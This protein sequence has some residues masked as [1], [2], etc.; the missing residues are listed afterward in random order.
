[1]VNA[2]IICGKSVFGM[3]L[4]LDAFVRLHANDEDGVTYREKASTTATSLKSVSCLDL[5]VPLMQGVE[6]AQPN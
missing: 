6:Q 5:V 3:A 2:K 4:C 1:M